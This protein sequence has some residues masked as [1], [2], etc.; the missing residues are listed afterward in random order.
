GFSNGIDA[1]NG[2]QVAVINAIKFFNPDEIVEAGDVAKKILD[3]VI[4]RFPNSGA[5][6]A[7][8]GIGINEYDLYRLVYS[9][10][11]PDNSYTP[12]EVSSAVCMTMLRQEG[13]LTI[14]TV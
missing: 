3:K 7:G 12:I 14:P 8:P 5:Y 11:I 2:N 4:D 13:I 9:N 10:Q 6:L 1:Q